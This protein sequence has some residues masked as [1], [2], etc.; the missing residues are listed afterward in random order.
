MPNICSRQRADWRKP[1]FIKEYYKISDGTMNKLIHT[2]GFPVK[3]LS[4]RIAR[5]DFSKTDEW[6]D[7]NW[8]S[9]K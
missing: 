2:D 7:K 6:F 1:S 9:I 5:I 3:W 4:T 8:Q